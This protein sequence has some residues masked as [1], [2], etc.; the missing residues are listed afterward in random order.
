MGLES[1]YLIFIDKG[2]S[3]ETCRWIH[4]LRQF[5][6]RSDPSAY[7]NIGIQFGQYPLERST[8]GELLNAFFESR[9]VLCSGLPTLLERR[10]FL[11]QGSI[12]GL[13][14]ELLAEHALLYL[15]IF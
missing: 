2:F 8:H 4:K 3:T 1:A 15:S 13:L 5:F 11:D 9:N 7:R 10:A 6:T 12:E 14:P